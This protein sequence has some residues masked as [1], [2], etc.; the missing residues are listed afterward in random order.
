MMYAIRLNKKRVVKS[1]LFE[2]MLFLWKN[3]FQKVS[4]ST[5]KSCKNML[6]FYKADTLDNIIDLLGKLK[7]RLASTPRL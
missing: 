1:I 2:S 3:N 7:E 5:F 4:K 6:Y